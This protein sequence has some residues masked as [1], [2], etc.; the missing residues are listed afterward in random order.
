M[1]GFGLY[2]LGVIAGTTLL[3]TRK[4]QQV[5]TL[6]AFFQP[7]AV[8][9]IA[10]ELPQLTEDDFI[11]SAW[12]FVGSIPYEAIGSD[13]EFANGRV[14]CQDCYLPTQTLTRKVGNCVAKSSLL[15][16]I[17]ANKI[18]LSRIQIVI[19]NYVGESQGGHAWVELWKGDNWY[20]LEAT[21]TPSSQPWVI[22]TSA[23][24]SYQPEI[25]LES[26]RLIHLS[27]HE[28]EKMLNGYS[29]ASC[30]CYRIDKN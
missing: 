11:I 6:G 16:S 10:Q 28:V 3:A 22:A 25:V 4:T 24:G 12:Q 9:S 27:Q 13:M 23:Y 2:M 29:Y 20:L 1:L 17:L 19:G 30:N 21:K 7:A 26:N 18:S 15:A 5:Y 8:S 14:Y